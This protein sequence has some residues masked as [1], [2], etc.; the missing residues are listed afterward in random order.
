[1][2]NVITWGSVEAAGGRTVRVPVPAG[3]DAEARALA[4]RF[5]AGNVAGAGFQ[6]ELF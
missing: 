6:T 4:E 3:R 2:G 5:N 1:M